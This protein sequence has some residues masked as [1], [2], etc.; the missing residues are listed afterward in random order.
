MGPA[1]PQ[2]PQTDMEGYYSFLQAGSELENTLQR[3][4][5]T[6]TLETVNSIT[7]IC[8]IAVV[9]CCSST[10]NTLGHKIKLSLH[11]DPSVSCLYI[12]LYD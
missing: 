9:E 6:N 12:T 1:S 3:E 5:F 10:F 4:Y 7:P 11:V 2:Q 8:F